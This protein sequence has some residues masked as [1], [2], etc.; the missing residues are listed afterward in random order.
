MTKKA[1]GVPPLVPA[2]PIFQ[3]SFLTTSPRAG[4]IISKSN[5]TDHPSNSPPK[6]RAS[7]RDKVAPPYRTIG[8]TKFLR[9]HS[10]PQER[11]IFWEAYMPRDIWRGLQAQRAPGR[12]NPLRKYVCGKSQ[13][14]TKSGDIESIDKIP[15]GKERT[16]L[17]RI[18]NLTRA[19]IW[20]FLD[21][22]RSCI[23]G[24]VC[25][26]L[27]LHESSGGNTVSET[28][29]E[30]V[31]TPIYAPCDC[32]L[33]LYSSTSP[34]AKLKGEHSAYRSS[35]SITAY[36]MYIRVCSC[37]FGHVPVYWC[38]HRVHSCI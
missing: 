34:L 15:K 17:R 23:K 9:Q 13:K 16:L 1:E 22:C 14:A 36:Y 2:S 18:A 11:R 20:Y 4:N 32:D 3:I 24:V 21:A 29:A 31:S 37:V 19:T 8:M 27:D 35:S 25:S 28:H 6:M 12:V 30:R 26:P 33:A 5:S 7:F 38:M 10:C